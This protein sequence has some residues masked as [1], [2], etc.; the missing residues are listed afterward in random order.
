MKMQKIA[1]MIVI[2]AATVGLVGLQQATANENWHHGWDHHSRH[3]QKLDKATLAKMEKFRTET[4]ALQK[5]IVMKRAEEDALIRSE[6]PNITAVKK[7]AG[8]LFELK[9][10]MLAKAKA[11]GLF[12]L[13]ERK[14]KN[15]KISSRRAK[16]EKF[17]SETKGIRKQIFEVRAEEQALLH[18]QT[19]NPQAV[20]KLAGQLFD[21]HN[22][23]QDKAVA[24]GLPW[25]APRH[26]GRH[27]HHFHRDFGING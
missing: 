20:A 21:L 26:E 9:Q 19:P 8:E 27:G 25:R 4:S 13:K 24:A 23:L 22:T 2:L 14:E 12:P 18:S 1:L 15:E 5:Q 10:T 17:F 11:A 6:K 16:L 3:F 7:A